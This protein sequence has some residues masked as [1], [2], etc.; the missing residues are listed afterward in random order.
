MANITTQYPLILDTAASNILSGTVW[1]SKVRWV[2]ASSAG[3]VATLIDGLGNTIWSS[4]AS[5]SN[6]VEVDTYIGPAFL[7]VNGDPIAG[8]G[9]GVST[10]QSGK[11][12]I[13]I[14]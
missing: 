2:G 9:L 13:Y 1:I 8:N 14:A 7:R 10:L 11:L 3:H 4:V 12:Y 5:G 6:Y